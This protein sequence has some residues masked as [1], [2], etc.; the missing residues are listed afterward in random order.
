MNNTLLRWPRATV[1]A[2]AM[3][4]CTAVAQENTDPLVAG[5]EAFERGDVVNAMAS[6]E[7]AA[8]AGSAEAQSK[9]AWILDG[10]EHNESAVRYYRAAAEQGYADGEFGLASM[11]AKGEGIEKDYDAAVS[12][13]ERAAA[14][15]HY[16]AIG[17]L[18]RAYENGELGLAVDAEKAAYWRDRQ[19]QLV[20]SEA[21][22]G[23]AGPVE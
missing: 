7:V 16:R 23:D 8:E 15:G 4:A 14:Q 9:L 20:E 12:L 22:D 5:N 2:L 21:S 6:Y 11:Y 3:I 19:D 18:R 10:S 17:I 13:F 1:F